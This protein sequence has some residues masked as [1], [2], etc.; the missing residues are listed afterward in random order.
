MTQP[1]RGRLLRGAAG[2]VLAGAVHALTFAP[3]PLPGWALAITTGDDV[4]VG[5]VAFERRR[6]QWHLGYWLNRFFWGRGYMSEA[7]HGATERFLLRV[8][9]VEIR[10]GVFADNP[11]SLKVQEKTGFVPNVF[12]VLARRPDEF[13]AFFAYYDALMTRESGLSKAEKEMIVVATSAANQCTYCVVAH[14]ALLRIFSDNPLLGDQVAIN[15]RAADLRR[16]GGR[17]QQ[18]Q[19]LIVG[20]DQPGVV[21]RSDEVIGRGAHLVERIEVGLKALVEEDQ[22]EGLGAAVSG[23]RERLAKIDRAEIPA[24]GDVARR[25]VDALGQRRNLRRRSGPIRDLLHRGSR[26]FFGQILSIDQ[27]RDRLLDRHNPSPSPTRS[28]GAAPA[29]HYRHQLARPG[30]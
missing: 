23:R 22:I 19:V 10:S 28:P 8:P 14:G 6:E 9:G 25:R 30:P 5:V 4:H 7:V 18:R 11:A 3:G 15:H 24:V 17:R 16:G 12:L 21:G 27:A 1:P 29:A 13:R 2:L 20:R 26:F